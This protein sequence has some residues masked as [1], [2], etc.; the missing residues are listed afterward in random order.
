MSKLL[1][2]LQYWDGD[3]EMAMKVARLIA[4]ME[5]AHNADVD[6]LFCSRF[7]CTH[8]MDSVAHVAKKFRV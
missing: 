1:L 6:F 2:A 5:P 4:D 8:D 7:D 3:K